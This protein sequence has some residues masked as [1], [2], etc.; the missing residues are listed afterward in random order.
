MSPVWETAS[1]SEPIFRVALSARG[2]DRKAHPRIRPNCGSHFPTGR[3]KGTAA[4]SHPFGNV[5]QQILLIKHED[6]RLL[7]ITRRK[8]RHVQEHPKGRE[9]RRS[10]NR[11]RSGADPAGCPPAALADGLPTPELEKSLTVDVEG[12]DS[13]AWF[14]DDGNYAIIEDYDLDWDD[15]GNDL[16]YGYSRLD[17]RSG[18]VTPIDLPKS[19]LSDVRITWDNKH[20]YWLDD[21]KVIV[22]SVE[23]QKQVAHPIHAKKSDVSLSELSE[24]GNTLTA[25]CPNSK[26]GE[27]Y[28]F[29]LQSNEKSF[30]YKF[31]KDDMDAVLSKDG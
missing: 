31:E 19:C 3:D 14:T 1:R 12:Q 11:H 28:V 20:L 23:D 9:D 18:E 15:D 16:Y 17:L 26:Y 5:A 6:T 4:L 22:Y 24:D 30:T 29:N 10:H 2:P 21:G 13:H 27:I 8:D 25:Y 7:R